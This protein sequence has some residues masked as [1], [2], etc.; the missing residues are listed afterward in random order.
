M[1]ID[2]TNS[3]SSSLSQ[4]PL[5]SFLYGYAGAPLMP[6]S[7]RRMNFNA[8]ANN[9][10]HLH[11]AWE[12]ARQNVWLCVRC[13]IGGCS[14]LRCMC[15]RIDCMLSECINAE[16]SF[17]R[18]TVLCHS[19]MCNGTPNMAVHLCR[20]VHHSLICCVFLIY[21]PKTISISIHAFF[22]KF[23]IKLKNIIR[24]QSQL[25]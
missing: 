5:S 14:A 17:K 24:Y 20:L 19:G 9:S 8:H 22:L 10:L 2:L 25:Q 15:W 6:S 18:C 3:F 4:T 23:K 21:M 13:V 12:R 11:G 1:F 16:C 7:V